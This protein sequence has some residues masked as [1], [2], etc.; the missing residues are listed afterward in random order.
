MFF[1]TRS[2]DVTSFLLH[3]YELGLMNY[4]YITMDYKLPDL[5]TRKKKALEGLISISTNYP[6]N[7]SSTKYVEFQEDCR[8]R[9]KLPPFERSDV[10]S[11]TKV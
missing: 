5:K 1:I 11:T 9:A 2:E 7:V 3:A 8:R 6:A 4:A 10:N